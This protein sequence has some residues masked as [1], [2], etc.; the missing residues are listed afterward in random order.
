MKA[1]GMMNS[2]SQQSEIQRSL[3]EELTERNG[4][5]LKGRPQI[6]PV[7]NYFMLKHKGIYNNVNF[8]ALPKSCTEQLKIFWAEKQRRYHLILEKKKMEVKQL[9]IQRGI[10][11]SE[12][13]L[14][15]FLSNRNI[16]KCERHN[17]STQNV[18]K[19]NINGVHIA[20]TI[21]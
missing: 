14:F 21:C 6:L 9:I 8:I 5:T 2:P 1:F 12:G 20:R 10:Q 13:F 16:I 18:Y 19:R 7:Y 11:L 3:L 17:S 4:I 15:I